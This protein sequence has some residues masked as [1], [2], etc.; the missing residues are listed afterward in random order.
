MDLRGI[1]FR[2]NESYSTKRNLS[3]KRLCDIV[4]ALTGERPK[5][6]AFLIATS[7]RYEYKNKGIDLFIDAVKRV[8]KSPDL[9][10]EIVAFIL[11]P[12]WVEG[13]RID[14]QNRLQSATYDATPLP[15]ALHHPHCFT[16]TIKTVC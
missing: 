11:V 7:G 4:E 1:L 2:R 16:I 12:A 3:R 15:A 5:K 10:R 8:S 13:P 9:E 6:N 14:L